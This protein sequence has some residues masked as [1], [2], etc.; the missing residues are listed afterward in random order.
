MSKKYRMTVTQQPFFS[1][2]IPSFDRPRYLE[3]CIE[4]ILK[5]DFKD[6]E[7]IISDDN[8][9]RIKEILRV[10]EP[11]LKYENITFIK[12]SHNLGMANNWNFL[13]FNAKGK[14]L[15]I[16]GDDDILLTCTLSRLKCYIENYP[17]YD[18]YCFGYS[19]IDENNKFCYL[20]YSYKI[21][22]ISLTYPKLIEKLF[23]AGIIPFWIFHPFTICYKREVSEQITYNDDVFI[24]SDLLF[25]FDCANI[26]KKM[27]VI[28]EALFYWRKMQGES[29]EYQ[30]LSNF[31]GSNI[32]ARRNIL[33]ILEQRSDL[34]PC[35]SKIVLS[36][37][38]RKRFLYDSIVIDKLIVK[39]G[40]DS[41]KLKK[42]HL[43]ELQELYNTGGY[44]YHRIR[45]KLYQMYEYIKVFGF[46]GVFRLILYGYYKLRFKSKMIK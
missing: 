46:K 27:L 6:F 18:L 1:V 19:V 17:D 32:I 23:V 33:D 12:Q 28:P 7:I 15:I 34:Q 2:L 11:Y 36:Y 22:E 25:L 43:E 8:S 20:Q 45:I 38:F 30:N 4:S 26:D 3:K 37:S 16:L 9:I 42:K 10:I 5:N 13:V 31:R 29:K 44:V 14:Y 40:F 41:L 24:G 21:F 35:I 39:S